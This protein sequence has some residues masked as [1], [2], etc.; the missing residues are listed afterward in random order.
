MIRQVREGKS[1][2]VVDLGPELGDIT[3]HRDMKDPAFL[4][5]HHGYEEGW[6]GT[7]ILG[8]GGEGRAGLW[9]KSDG[10]GQVIDVSCP[11]LGLICPAISDERGV[12]FWALANLHQTNRRWEGSQVAQTPR[13]QRHGRSGENSE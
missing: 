13:S 8:E 2:D 11:H 3:H 9:E 12:F 10:D 7:R 5:S 6:R 1:Y 4:Q